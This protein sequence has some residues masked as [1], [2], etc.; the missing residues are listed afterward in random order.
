M[1]GRSARFE[2]LSIPNVLSVFRLI[3]IPVFI[4][5]FFST[6]RSRM[7]LAALILILSGLTD[8][9]DGMIARN[10]NLITE[11]GKI[12][13]PVADKLTQA[14]V[15]VCLFLD[16]IFPLWLL[17]LF[18]AKEGLM[19]AGGATMLK[20]DKKVSSSKWYGKLATV[21]FYIVMISVIAFNPPY[22]IAFS[23]IVVALAFMLFAFGMYLRDYLGARSKSN[24]K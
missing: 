2:N 16:G 13:D 6:L 15:C 17:L 18:I 1:K 22:A 7:I 21:V 8:I 11:L 9:L 24:R 5:T 10:F 23:L 4:L 19:L 12:L 20:K 3:L 14:T